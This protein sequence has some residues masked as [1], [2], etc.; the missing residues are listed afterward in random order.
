MFGKMKG[1]MDQM[2]MMQRLMKDENFR[3]FVSHPKVQELF[4]DPTFKEVAKTQD[5][6]KIAAHPKFAA[7]LRDPEVAALMAKINPQQLMQK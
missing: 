7:V 1:M 3:A 6:M 2:Q 5:F 4:K